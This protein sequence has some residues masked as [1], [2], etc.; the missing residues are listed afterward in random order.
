MR[1]RTVILGMG[2]F[3]SGLSG[4]VGFRIGERS[5]GARLDPKAFIDI[6]KGVKFQYLSQDLLLKIFSRSISDAERKQI[7]SELVN[8]NRQLF[9]QEPYSRALGSPGFYR[10]LG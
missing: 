10:V 5:N 4:V 1:R 6:N 2:I 7:V 3:A 8:H 9:V